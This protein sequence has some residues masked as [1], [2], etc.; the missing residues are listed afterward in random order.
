[1]KNTIIKHSPLNVTLEYY[2]FVFPRKI[3]VF[4]LSELNKKYLLDL[5]LY[6]NIVKKPLPI[7][8]IIVTNK[9][10][11]IILLGSCSKIQISPDT[12]MQIGRGVLLEFQSSS[13]NRVLT[14]V[15]HTESAWR[16]WIFSWIFESNVMLW[17]KL[18]VFQTIKLFICMWRY[19]ESLCICSKEHCQSFES[20]YSRVPQ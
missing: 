1:M 12:S 10:D 9:N 5:F 8:R 16:C 15:Y 6:V 13:K 19:F 7:S 2:N 4:P 14:E 18:L 3:I 17:D 20:K 11:T